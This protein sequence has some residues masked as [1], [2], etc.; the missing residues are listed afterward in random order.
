MMAATLAKGDTIIRNAAREP[1]I[2]DIQ[3]FLN[4]WGLH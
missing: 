4:K 1:E 2:E 3:D